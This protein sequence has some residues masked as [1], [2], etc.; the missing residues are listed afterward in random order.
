MNIQIGNQQIRAGEKQSLMLPAGD[1]RT[2]LP[3]VAVNGTEKGPTVLISAGIHGAE[4][5]G[6]QTAME[7]SR[8]LEPEMVKGQIIILLLA[9]PSACHQYARFVVPEDGKNLNR[10]FPGR[11]D[12]SL[13]ERIAY[14]IV[15]ELQN[16]ADYYIDI[17]AG[18]TSEQVMPFAYFTGSAKEE[19]AETARRMAMSADMSVRARS[20][21]TT[22]AFSCAGVHG[23]PAVLLERGGGGVYTADEIR[24]YKQDVRNILIHLEVL[25]GEEVHQRA[26]GKMSPQREVRRASYIDAEHEGFWYPAYAA[27]DEFGEGD[28]LGEVTDIWGNCL[29]RYYADYAGIVLYQTVGMGIGAGDPLIAYGIPEER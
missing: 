12:G 22:G 20:S 8:E 5:I 1:G 17:H 27:G 4:Y 25:G 21:S 18:D 29:I 6:I 26:G 13:S 7:L 9:N 15:H 19:V 11:K 28:L 2:E 10:V 16:Q 24:L 23:I 14:T 3:V